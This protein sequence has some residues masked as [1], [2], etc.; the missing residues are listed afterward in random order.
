[1]NHIMFSKFGIVVTHIRPH[2]AILFDR[3]LLNVIEDILGPEMSETRNHVTRNATDINTQVIFTYLQMAMMRSREYLNGGLG[4]EK[5]EK[6]KDKKGKEEKGKKGEGEGGRIIENDS[7]QKSSENFPRR[8]KKSNSHFCFSSNFCC[9]FSCC[10]FSGENRTVTWNSR[11]FMNVSEVHIPALRKQREI[12]QISDTARSLSESE[13]QITLLPALDG[14]A[15]GRSS[16]FGMYEF[17]MLTKKD[18]TSTIAKQIS[19]KKARFIG[20][21]DDLGDT[22][23]AQW[24]AA[25]F[26]KLMENLWRTKAPWEK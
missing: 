6:G 9:N 16:K 7:D 10:Y 21:N 11:A 4:V 12:Q 17:R 22:S 24:V 20:I 1:M 13:L 23:R 19:D 15:A 25:F 5:D 8:E 3:E 14:I 18:F 2:S 26:T